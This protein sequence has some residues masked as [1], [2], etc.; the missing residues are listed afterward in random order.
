MIRT[1]HSETET[2]TGTGTGD[3]DIDKLQ[4][5]LAHQQQV[6]QQLQQSQSSRPPSSGMAVINEGTLGNYLHFSIRDALEAVPNFDGG[7][8]PFVHFVEGCEE[9][10]SM[11]T[12]T[13]EINLV[14]AVRNKLKGDAHRSILGQT[15]GK[16]Q[17]LVEFLRTKYGLR[18]T[19]YE[20]QGRLA[21]LY[22]KKD[23]KV[24]AYAN[25]IRELGKR[26]LDAQRRESGQISSEF[27]N[28]IKNH[29]KTS[30]LRGLDKEII[31]SKEG[32]FEEVQSRA[33]DAEKELETVKMI[34][35][36]VLAENTYPVKNEH[37]HDV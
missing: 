25:R 5:T 24:L 31:I 7:N 36:V 22:Q 14:R 15:F 13:Q 34:R 20:A 9:A 21:Y 30:F 3:M 12:P 29:L 16:I 8:I 18:E 19:V 27:R 11:I 23:E 28:S 33:I 2:P 1:P 37:Q 6:I 4:R 35:S 10:L 32:R 26:I 17:E